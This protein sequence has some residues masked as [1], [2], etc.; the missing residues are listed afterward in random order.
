MY[1]LYKYYEI[2]CS[3]LIIVDECD[4]NVCIKLQQTIL[5]SG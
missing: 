4:N 5:W 3:I 1:I 2:I